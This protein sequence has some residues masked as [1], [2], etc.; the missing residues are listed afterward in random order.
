MSS[1][2]F[3]H[4]WTSNDSWSLFHLENRGGSVK[5]ASPV[6]SITRVNSVV[7]MSNKVRSKLRY[8]ET[9]ISLKQNFAIKLG[10]LSVCPRQMFGCGVR[11]SD[12]C[13]RLMLRS[14]K[15]TGLESK[16]I[17]EAETHG[18]GALLLQTPTFLFKLCFSRKANEAFWGALTVKHQLR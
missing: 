14:V 2:A 17:G 18:R 6:Y 16:Q 3:C 7:P 8:A 11:S 5:A 4:V 13:Q 12:G 15:P 1:T 9:G 10:S